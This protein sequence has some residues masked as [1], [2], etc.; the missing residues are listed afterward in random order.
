MAAQ[1]LVDSRQLSTNSCRLATGGL[2]LTLGLPQFAPSGVGLL[3]CL[4]HLDDRRGQLGD[5]IGRLL[6]IAGELG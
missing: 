1:E 3:T 4:A 6:L 2:H 5:L